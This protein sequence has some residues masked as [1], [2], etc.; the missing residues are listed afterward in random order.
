MQFNDYKILGL[1]LLLAWIS[2]FDCEESNL[3]C[4][5]LEMSKWSLGT[6]KNFFDHLLLARILG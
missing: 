1:E 3:V 5:S 2:D 6:F 4:E